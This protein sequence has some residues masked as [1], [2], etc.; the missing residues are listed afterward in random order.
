MLLEQ[1]GLDFITGAHHAAFTDICGK[2][3]EKPNL[4]E[5]EGLGTGNGRAI[6]LT[7]ITLTFPS[8]LG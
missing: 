6:A 8:F 1:G 4:L 7:A 3:M 5:S 2:L